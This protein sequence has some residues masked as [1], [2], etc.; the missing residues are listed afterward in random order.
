MIRPAGEGTFAVIDKAPDAY[1]TISEVAEDLDLPQHVLR[2][3]ETRFSQI[4]P[5]KRGGGRRYYRPDDVELLKGIRQLLYA[6]GYTIKGVQRIL[7]EQGPKAVQSVVRSEP[8]EEEPPQPPPQRIDPVLT[9][10]PLARTPVAPAP[11][12]PAYPA[13]PAYVEPLADDGW[14]PVPPPQPVPARPA[15]VAAPAAPHVRA[16]MA[17]P[18]VVPPAWPAQPP[19]AASPM[20]DLFSPEDIAGITAP[21]EPVVAMPV[22][23]PVVAPP[24][25]PTV[26]FMRGGLVRPPSPPVAAPPVEE[27]AQPSPAVDT[28]AP[29]INVRRTI[30]PMPP[31]DEAPARYSPLVEP[32]LAEVVVPPVRPMLTEESRRALQSALFELTECRRVIER[33]MATRA[34]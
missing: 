21:A 7:K 23:E 30:R 11:P 12:P 24:G 14:R 22:P 9:Q 5:L 19:V 20:P 13:A 29:A 16:E 18:V 3:W 8:D 34:R 1:R 4:K 6:E 28:T 32:E 26:S 15:P 27:V 10:P 2:F 31:A 25:R 33:V 17:P